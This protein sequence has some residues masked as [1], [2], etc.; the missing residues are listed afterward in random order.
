MLT[1]ESMSTYIRQDSFTG[2]QLNADVKALGNPSAPI[3]HTA[4]TTSAES[5]LSTMT[6][7]VDGHAFDINRNAVKS[8]TS[9][10]CASPPPW[11]KPW[12]AGLSWV[13]NDLVVIIDPLGLMRV[14]TSHQPVSATIVLMCARPYEPHWAMAVD[15]IREKPHFWH[16]VQQRA[17][18]PVGWHCP[19]DWFHEV[20]DPQGASVTLLDHDAVMGAIAH[21]YHDE[22]DAA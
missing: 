6:C 3:F 19:T 17:C 22:P 9:A 18:L 12:I 8:V 15:S 11:A 14:L 10:I 5:Q 1:R 2:K 7:L 20:I 4:Q 21:R 13:N 16:G